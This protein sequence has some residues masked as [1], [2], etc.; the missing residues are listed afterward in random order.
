MA[1]D[2]ITGTSARA[3]ELESTNGVIMAAADGRGLSV[4]APS[5]TAITI[6]AFWKIP[7]RPATR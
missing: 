5:I 1:P 4:L 6:K 2:G 7:P 3:A